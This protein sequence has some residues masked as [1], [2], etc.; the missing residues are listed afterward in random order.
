MIGEGFVYWILVE[1][2]RSDYGCKYIKLAKDWL[3]LVEAES[4]LIGLMWG[5]KKKDIGKFLKV[6]G[7]GSSK[8]RFAF[9]QVGRD[10]GVERVWNRR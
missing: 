5:S 3:G 8:C 9:S 6:F 4:F 7:L 10:H 2:G 1:E